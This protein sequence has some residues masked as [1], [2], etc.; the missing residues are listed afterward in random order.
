MKT[1]I[2][3]AAIA[4]A[5]LTAITTS[6]AEAK[7]CYVRGAVG[8][9]GGHLTQR[10]ARAGAWSDWQSKMRT[11][12]NRRFP[13]RQ[14]ITANGYPKTWKENRRWKAQ[15]KAYGCHPSPLNEGHVAINGKTPCGFH[16]SRQQAIANNCD[17]WRP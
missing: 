7:T 16:K 2:V 9:T 12:Y 6:Q 11:A 15:I 17:S 4:F 3:A 13:Y 14:A 1:A 5:G 8:S 10:A